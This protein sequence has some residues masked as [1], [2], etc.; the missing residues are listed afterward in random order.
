[1]PKKP[2]EQCGIIIFSVLTFILAIIF[3]CEF[4]IPY[5]DYHNY[6]VENCNITKIEYP[7]EA[8][9]FDNTYGWARCDC[10]KHCN[11]WSPCIKLFSENHDNHLINDEYYDDKNKECTFHSKRCPDGE[12]LQIL[13]TYLIEANNTYHNYINQSVVCYINDP[14]THI[15]LSMPNDWLLIGVSLGTALAIS[16]LILCSCCICKFR[17]KSNSSNIV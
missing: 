5:L 8:P 4:L 14:I 17:N 11:S 12:N 13:E 2:A 3:L 16:F 6:S 1:M 7:T 9:T 15:Y 10:G